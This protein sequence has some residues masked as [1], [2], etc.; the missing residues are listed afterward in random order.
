MEK[1]ELAWGRLRA[2]E[3]EPWI[4]LPAAFWEL[5][6]GTVS[7]GMSGIGDTSG[8][9]S[10]PRTGNRGSPLLHLMGAVVSWAPL[11]SDSFLHHRGRATGGKAV[12]LFWSPQNTGAGGNSATHHTGIPL[13]TAGS[14]CAATSLPCVPV[15]ILPWHF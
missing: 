1:V 6:W 15:L 12:L 8:T 9:G 3:M 11:V 13:P 10:V 14:S 2:L 7:P 5:E 4:L